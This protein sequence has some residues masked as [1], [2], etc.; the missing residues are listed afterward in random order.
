[1]AD[2]VDSA[3]KGVEA[4]GS[5]PV[6]DCFGGLAELEQLSAGDDASLPGGERRDPLLTRLAH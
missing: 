4:S 6:V 1:M 3:I 5:Q 2:E